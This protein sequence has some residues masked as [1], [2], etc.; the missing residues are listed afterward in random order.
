MSERPAIVVMRT[1]GRWSLSA[2]MAAR[3]DTL[4]WMTAEQRAQLQREH[5]QDCAGLLAASKTKGK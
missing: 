2:I 4:D 3:G 1:G 5:Q